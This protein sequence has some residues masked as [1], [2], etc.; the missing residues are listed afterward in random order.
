MAQEDDIE[1]LPSEKLANELNFQQ[2][3]FVLE[4]LVNGGNGTRA[5][6]AAGYKCPAE[7]ASRLIRHP[8]VVA[9]IEA[10]RAERRAELDLALREKHLTPD[11]IIADLSEM[12][13]FDLGDLLDD[14]GRVDRGKIKAKAKQLQ[15]VEIDG[16]KT[17]IKG[18]DRLAA[19]RLLMDYLG[20][21][22]QPQVNVQ[23]NL[24]FGERLAMRRARAL[25]A[26]Q[27]KGGQ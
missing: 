27:L 1:L 7:T 14:L 12:A 13:G 18:P 16:S 26:A 25:E 4:Y 15:A 11:R 9:F 20:M 5:A 23:V 21:T 22:K 8:K 10:R 3:Q 19:Y 24:G 17:K 6:T 2:E